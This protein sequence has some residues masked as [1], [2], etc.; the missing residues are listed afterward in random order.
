M[1]C[2]STASG[3]STDIRWTC[4]RTKTQISTNNH[5]QCCT[6]LSTTPTDVR[7]PPIHTQN[8]Q[9]S[10]GELVN[11]FQLLTQIGKS[12]YTSLHRAYTSHIL[13]SPHSS[14][15]T[16]L[17]KFMLNTIILYYTSSMTVQHTPLRGKKSTVSH[18][19]M[20]TK[21]WKIVRSI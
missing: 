4:S 19:M 13:H 2:S 21:R 18:S 7:S 1:H 12:D 3:I 15:W 8:H 17:L 20:W 9:T 5:T 6:H 10:A 11:I 14:F 16:T